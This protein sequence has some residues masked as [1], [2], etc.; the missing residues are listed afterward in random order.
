MKTK[1]LKKEKPLNW[2]Q[3]IEYIFTKEE[4]KILKKLEKLN[5][6]VEER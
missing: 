6:E 3:N 1:Q 4:L 5:K 2:T